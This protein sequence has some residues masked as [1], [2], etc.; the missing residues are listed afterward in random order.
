MSGA[1][2][3]QTGLYGACI[4]MVGMLLFVI[5]ARAP[6]LLLT[7]LL[8]TV[9]LTS[10]STGFNP[11]TV[12]S[13]VHVYPGDVFTVLLIATGLIRK[14]QQRSWTPQDTVFSC[15]TIL[16][17]G[18]F[19]SSIPVLS[20]QA[21]VNHSRTLF[22]AVGAYFWAASMGDWKESLLA[23]FIWVALVGATV[24]N[25]LYLKNGFGSASDGYFDQVSGQWV[26]ARPLQASA[27]LIML[28]GLLAILGRSGPWTSFRATAALY[29]AA[30]V[31]LAQHRSVWIAALVSVGLLCAMKLK[32][33][34]QGVFAILPVMSAAIPIGLLIFSLIS[35]STA[36]TQSAED[37]GTMDARVGLWSDRMAVPRSLLEWLTGGFLGPTPVQLDPR[38]QIEA[39][40]M[41]IQTIT[42]GGLIGLTLIVT[43]LVLAFP[44]FGDSQRRTHSFM[45]I[46][47][48]TFGFFYTW[49]DWSFVLLG[50]GCGYMALSR[51]TTTNAVSPRVNIDS[52]TRGT[53]SA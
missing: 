19:L 31:V 45:L 22:L 18:A 34:R 2:L 47:I 40:N 13:G 49:P 41:Y 10:S 50:L 12:V 20:L 23:P 11:S 53:V 39:H 1:S 42:S 46:A 4:L 27:A 15:F 36:L 9:M 16:V 24:Q 8:L 44:K 14:L 33:S 35:N 7:L 32:T 37:T 48:V 51:S 25:F 21:S 43:T 5:T 26:S 17:L 6:R 52:R 38:F 30:S 29:L 28:C 3:L